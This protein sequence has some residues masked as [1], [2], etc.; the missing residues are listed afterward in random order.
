MEVYMIWVMWAL[1]SGLTIGA[2]A[3]FI[4]PGRDPGGVFI[5]MLLGMMGAVLAQF[6]VQ[7]FEW[8]PRYR[9]VGFI[10]S[11]LGAIFILA[12]YRL[13]KKRQIHSV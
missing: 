1:I 12:I 9:K 7:L 11:L 13:I 6:V 8:Y 4:M 10:P 2:A 5:T 3:K